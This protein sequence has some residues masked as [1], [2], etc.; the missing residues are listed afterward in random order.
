MSLSP[1]PRKPRQPRLPEP[2]QSA[3]SPRP[4][5]QAVEPRRTADP[6]TPPLKE[7]AERERLRASLVQE[8]D[9]LV[10]D[11][12]LADLEPAADPKEPARRR[13]PVQDWANLGKNEACAAPVVAAV[14]DGLRPSAEQHVPRLLAAARAAG[15]STDQ[16]AYLLGTVQHET[17]FGKTMVERHPRDYEG[18]KQLGNSVPGDGRRFIGRGFIQLTGRDLYTRAST[19]V[20][21][22][23]V[24]H[25]ETA[26]DPDV[27]AT[28]AAFGM[29]DGF[30][31]GAKLGRYVNAHDV[32]FYNAR[33]VINGTDAADII[34]DYAENYRS[35]LQGC[36]TAAARGRADG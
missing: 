5:P 14:P 2:Y 3:W 23:L 8:A 34:A 18:W 33:R 16:V 11:A 28:I 26:T 36:S 22:D 32:D 30:F 12:G 10:M 20:G 17:G 13:Y 35:V 27:S 4:I 24:S 7:L 19:A 31:T 25:P 21:V 29:R 15:L 1:E 9:P 6:P